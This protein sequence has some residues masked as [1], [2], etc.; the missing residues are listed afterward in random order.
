MKKMEPFVV[1]F[2]KMLINEEQTDEWGVTY[3]SNET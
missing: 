3:S 1:P 2:A